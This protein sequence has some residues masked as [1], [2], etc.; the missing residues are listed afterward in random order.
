MDIDAHSGSTIKMTEKHVLQKANVVHSEDT[1][2][3]QHKEDLN[4]QRE[5]SS[6]SPA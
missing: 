5:K 3:R 4:H 6:P 1:K 2:Q